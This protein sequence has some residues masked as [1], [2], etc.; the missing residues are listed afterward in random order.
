MSEAPVNVPTGP[1]AE[2][3][4]FLD[5]GRFMLQLSPS[6]GS[7]VFYPRVLVPDS[8]ETDL[9]WVPA[10]GLGTLYAITVNRSRDGVYN[11]ALVDLNEGPRMMSR[12]VDCETAPIGCRLQAQIAELDG[13]KAVVFRRI[14]QVQP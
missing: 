2:Y 5:E 3:Q 1:Q 7:Y 11:I 9:Q 8:G 14:G 13:V 4:A 12:I 6:T 10:S